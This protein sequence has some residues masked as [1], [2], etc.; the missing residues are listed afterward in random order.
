M[1]E[2]PTGWLLAPATGCC[3]AAVL[4]AIAAGALAPLTAAPPALLLVFEPG[5]EGAVIPPAGSMAVGCMLVPGKLSCMVGSAP[6]PVLAQDNG[7]IARTGSQLCI[8]R[9][10]IVMKFPKRRDQVRG[11]TNHPHREGRW[12]AAFH[13]L[14][15]LNFTAP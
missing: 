10:V 7:R 11:L 3:G 14:E 15:A 5:C 2:L 6:E 9:R 13:N 1:G 12:D 8:T 4:P